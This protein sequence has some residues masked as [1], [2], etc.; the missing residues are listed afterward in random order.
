MVRSCW[1]LKTMQWK[2]KAKILCRGNSRSFLR[3]IATHF[4]SFLSMSKDGSKAKSAN[5]LQNSC[6]RGHCVR[7]E[8]IGSDLCQGKII[9]AGDKNKRLHRCSKFPLC[10]LWDCQ[11]RDTRQPHTLKLFPGNEKRIER[12]HSE[13]CFLIATWG[14]YWWFVFKL[15]YSACV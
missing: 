4:P 9:L 2:A 8:T 13:L 5:E 12:L 10:G 7:V 15:I 14:P 11:D 1:Q 3:Q 6:S